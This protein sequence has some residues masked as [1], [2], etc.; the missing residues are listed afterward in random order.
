MGA[1]LRALCGAPVVFLGGWDVVLGGNHVVDYVRDH[2]YCAA[3]ASPLQSPSLTLSHRCSLGRVSHKSIN[4]L[5]PDSLNLS[6]QELINT[7]GL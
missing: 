1:W 3:A 7:G 2:G 6:P 5:W 4:F